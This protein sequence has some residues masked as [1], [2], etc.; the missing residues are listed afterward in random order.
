M[1][2]KPAV[3]TLDHDP[4]AGTERLRPPGE[5]A[6]AWLAPVLALVGT[7]AM[8]WVVAREPDPPP[9][10]DLPVPSVRPE[11]TPTPS[12]TV[13]VPPAVRVDATIASPLPQP[14]P[15]APVTARE[16]PARLNSDAPDAAGNATT[17]PSSDRPNTSSDVPPTAQP[18]G[19]ATVTPSVAAPT[20]TA[21]VRA[22][23]P[24]VDT[25]A[26]TASPVPSSPVAPPVLAAEALPPVVTAAAAPPCLPIVTVS[27][28]HDST[29][30]ILEGREK[31]ARPLVD[32]IATHP[33]AVLSVEGHA[34][35]VGTEDYNIVLSFGRA[36]AVAGWLGH[37]GVP[38]TRIAPRAAGTTPAKGLPAD[39]STN[40]LVVLQ[41]EGV[42]V[43][44]DTGGATKRP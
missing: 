11:T 40:R 6:P 8:V 42:D 39:V 36:R 12:A 17:A 16:I 34:D 27:F 38:A 43:C 31:A 20:P 7:L 33:E 1:R 37:L 4:S 23:S 24:A 14:P 5:D 28:A 22:P 2:G 15:T 29:K 44:R 21:E 35:T 32:W 18:S 9:P 41:I 25:I 19:G 26:V 3:V 30:P 13:V 10:L